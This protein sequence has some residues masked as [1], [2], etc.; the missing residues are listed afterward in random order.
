[1]RKLENQEKVLSAIIHSQLLILLVTG[2]A[3][4]LLNF[5]VLRQLLGLLH[6]VV[7]GTLV[8]LILPYLYNHI[9]RVHSIK[10]LGMFVG[11]ILLML[12]TLASVVSGTTLILFGHTETM[13]SMIQLH[14]IS[15]WVVLVLTLT[16]LINHY[17]G[18]PKHRI[19]TR[20]PYFRT[21]SRFNRTLFGTITAL[22]VMGLSIHLIDRTSQRPYQHAAAV[23]PYQYDYG[24]D[25]FMPSRTQLNGHQFIDERA[26]AQSKKC[27]SCHQD[28]ARQWHASAHRQAAS[29]KAYETNVSLL[30]DSVGISATRYCEGCHAPVALLTGQL[31]EGGLHG[32]ID[33]STANLEGVNCVSCHGISALVNTQGVASYQFSL[34]QPYLFDTAE[35]ELLQSINLLLIDLFPAQHKTNMSASVQS[36]SAY[37]ASCHSQFIDEQVNQW[38]WIK[39]QD[40]YAAW[41]QSPFSGKHDR[42]F[43]HPQQQRCQ[44]CHMPL[45]DA[46][47]PSANADGQVRDHRFIGA[48]TMLPLLAGDQEQLQLTKAFLQANKM[49]ISIDPPSRALAT[50]SSMKVDPEL[51]DAAIKPHYVYRG[52]QVS[53]DVIVS[54]TGVGHNFPRRHH[55]YQSGLGRICGLRC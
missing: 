53:I 7:G 29:D 49:H 16:H 54:N 14:F 6:I 11:G 35:S 43:S 1:M 24:K 39:M 13:H 21:F 12:A 45:V 5:S 50:E 48:N 31:S 17:V 38:G 30:A 52:E 27:A 28:I 44:D 47:D 18:H 37:C 32:G 20:E 36:T 40:E 42:Q 51:L 46:A 55:R 23:E 41:L 8:V 19:Q 10:R 2:L 4:N 22:V 9:T 25:P 34:P 3:H 33:D 26:I 15:A